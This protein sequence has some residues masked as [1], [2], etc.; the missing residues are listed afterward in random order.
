M[1]N[2][3]YLNLKYSRTWKSQKISSATKKALHEI[4]IASK[5]SNKLNAKSLKVLNLAVKY[6]QNE[7]Y[8]ALDEHIKKSLLIENLNSDISNALKSIQS[9]ITNSAQTNK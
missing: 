4:Q 9:I 3:I 8:S 6:Y 2:L 7:D 1:A 5:S